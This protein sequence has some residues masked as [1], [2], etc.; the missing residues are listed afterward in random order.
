[1]SKQLVAQKYIFKINTARLRKAK[2]NLTLTLAEARRNDEIISIGDS[3]MLRWIDEM[4]GCE[5]AEERVREIKRQ[6]KHIRRMGDSVQN[7]RAIRRLYDELDSVQFKPDYMHLVIDKNKDL[8]RACRGFLINGIKYVR[9]LGTSGGVKNSTVV[10]VSERLASRLRVRID[11]GRNMNMPLVPAKFEAYRALT[12]SGSTP[13]SMPRGILVVPDCETVFHEDVLFL[14]DENDGEPEL[15]M[16]KDY[17]VK[18]TESDGYGLMLPTL[19]ERWS[20][21]LKLGYTAGGLNTRFAWEKGMVFAFD[22]VDFAEKIARSYI[23]H[24][25]WGN[26]VDIRNVELILTT[27]M[28][29][30]W[31]S[32]ESL[33]QYLKC[34]EENHYTFG[35]TK[36]SPG[37]LENRRGTNYQ[38]LQSYCLDDEQLRTLVMPTIDEIRDV[39][40]G[41]Y[42]KAILFMAG[43]KLDEDSIS[44]Q[45]DYIKAMM[46]EPRMFGD[47]YI[48]QKIKRAI[49]RRI[50]DAKIGVID[51]HGNYSILCGDPYALC[52][53]VFG[54]RVTGLLRAGEIYNRYWVD[55]GA[56]EVVCFRAPMSTHENIRK[57]RVA[58]S[59]EAAYW[60]QYI[61][62]CTLTNAWDTATQAWN[63]A[64]KDGD[65][66][67]LTDNPVLLK[68]TR[69]L[70]AL[71]CAQKTAEKSV[72]TEDRLIRANIA[73]FGNDV[74]RVTNWVTS[75]YDVQ[76]Q[77]EPD[78]EEYRILDYRIKCGQLYQQ[79]TIDKTKGIVCKPMPRYWHDYMAIKRPDDGD[80][81]AMREY[82]INKRIVASRKPYFMRYIYPVLMRDY[83]AYVKNANMK[84]V[85]EFR[86]NIDEIKALEDDELTERQAEFI[87]YYE[88]NMPVGDHDCLMNRIC[89]LVEQELGN[90]SL[91]ADE[92]PFDYTIMKSGAPYTQWQM[93][94]VKKL[95]QNH[96]DAIK[97]IAIKQN[98][99][100]VSGES[101]GDYAASI[102]Q[103]FKRELIYNCS[104]ALAGCDIVLDICYQR[105][106]TKQFAWDV[107]GSQ[108][109]HNLAGRTGYTATFPVAD[110]DGDISYR[111][112]TY[113]M[114]TTEVDFNGDYFE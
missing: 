56:E 68:N 19:A 38:F 10:F 2:W 108:I 24:D 100:Q 69:P 67:M 61:R 64:D 91:R 47:P 58:R 45:P 73:S 99:S 57:M 18:L 32:Y 97:E 29:K 92:L 107:S 49:S 25:V 87:R 13:V 101:F 33:E 85:C 60:Y 105:A 8:L 114:I 15:R 53:S 93:A 65:L 21:E 72:I 5:G 27:S 79:N 89:R 11:N 42:R 62:T 28:L 7:R 51:V 17:E 31:S 34:C 88:Y 84:A 110:P 50:D 43:T 90:E 30:L 63:G 23:V 48:R 54:L 77:F 103:R 20:N 76:A 96:Q 39:V 37:E 22:F 52:Q 98:N 78:S 74:G 95:F 41:D 102:L 36:A 82:R 16:I 66:L 14:S 111:G 40:R 106:S 86:K 70:P 44:R 4:N 113:S 6:I 55:C 35:V 71:Y 1:M 46:L 109:L 81:E 80:E 9:L 26:E 104:N 12:C 94:T 112:E 75:M 83:N 59:E 3:Q